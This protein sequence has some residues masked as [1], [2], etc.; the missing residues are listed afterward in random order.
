MNYCKLLYTLPLLLFISCSDD[1]E[2]LPKAHTF[3]PVIVEPM[4]STRASDTNNNLY[5]VKYKDIALDSVKLSPSEVILLKSAQSIDTVSIDVYGY[6]GWTRWET[7]RN[8]VYSRAFSSSDSIAQQC[9]I[10]AGVYLT[11]DVYLEQTY[12]LPTSYAVILPNNDAYSSNTT[13]IGWNPDNTSTRGYKST[14]SGATV[15]LQTAAYLIQYTV[16][17]Q[18]V[19]K[20][21][22]VNLSN[23][24]WKI[25]YLQINL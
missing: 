21:Y 16:S 18:Q 2:N 3:S 6:T 22:P 5:I 10:A 11:R 1:M 25:K 24:V 15:S 14:L 23:L 4:P 8:E 19:W 9:G 13:K 20:T 17:G 7:G 12:T